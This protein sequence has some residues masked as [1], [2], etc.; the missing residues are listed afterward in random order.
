VSPEPLT[1]T[2]ADATAMS[3]L[4]RMTLLRRVNDGVLESRKICGRRVIV[5]ASLRKLLGFDSGE[6]EAAA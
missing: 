4:S 1:V 2:L 6:H 5:V 3:G